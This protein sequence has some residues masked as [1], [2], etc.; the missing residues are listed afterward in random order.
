MGILRGYYTSMVLSETEL[1]KAEL[2][3]NLKGLRALSDDQIDKLYSKRKQYTTH[4]NNTINKIKE[5]NIK[6]ECEIDNFEQN[7]TKEIVRLEKNGGEQ[8]KFSE[9]CT[10]AADN[11]FNKAIQFKNNNVDI[12]VE[13]PYFLLTVSEYAYRQGLSESG[14]NDLI[15]KDILDYVIDKKGNKL[16]KL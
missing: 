9:A 4:I 7:I 11:Y 5:V 10:D 6:A 3:E 14:V 16:I 13:E 1:S 2:N 15:K 8:F 12:I